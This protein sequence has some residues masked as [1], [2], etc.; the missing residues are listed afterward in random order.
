MN[1]NFKPDDYLDKSISLDLSNE[2]ES[3]IEKAKR[4]KDNIFNSLSKYSIDSSSDLVK[5]NTKFHDNLLINIEDD[6]DNS[7]IKS[8]Y[9]N[10]SFKIPENI[11]NSKEY[12]N[13]KN[14]NENNKD[15]KISIDNSLKDM[16]LKDNHI[17]DN[18]QFQINNFKKNI[19]ENNNN[20]MNSEVP[21]FRLNTS[22]NYSE[23]N[24]EFQKFKES[25]NFKIEIISMFFIYSL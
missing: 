15:L 24:N 25:Q 22:F 5:Q 1:W 7:L 2:L 17:E 4:D 16:D 6:E 9:S 21:S 19:D 8:I 10:I 11:F 14:N 23:I 20:N 3:I 12:I 13:L 18:F